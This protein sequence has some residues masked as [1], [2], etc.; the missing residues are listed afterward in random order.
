M[1]ASLPPD[2]PSVALPPEADMPAIATAAGAAAL[3]DRLYCDGRLYV[4]GVTQA[5]LDAA[6]G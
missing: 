3:E 5:A 1:S 6:A 2:W 4:R